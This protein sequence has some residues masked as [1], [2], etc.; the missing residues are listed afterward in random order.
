[1][2]TPDEL[3][4]FERAKKTLESRETYEEFL[5][6]LNLFTK[7]VVDTQTLIFWGRRFFGDGELLAQFKD[8]LG[9]D[10][11]QGNVE[12][13]PPGS[14]RTG[15]PEALSA[16][17]VVDGEGP[18]YRRLPESVSDLAICSPSVFSYSQHRKYA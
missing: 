6:L 7:D 16:Q 15:P 17:P 1:V 2:S 5:K 4:F 13:G 12:H 10:D 3:V 8:L 14:V 11:T 9:W 18:S